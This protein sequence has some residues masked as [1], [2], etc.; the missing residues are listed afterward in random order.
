MIESVQ[1]MIL[2][3][4]HLPDLINAEHEMIRVHTYGERLEGVLA[5]KTEIGA[6]ITSCFEDLQQLAQQ[7]FGIWGEADCEGQAA[8]P[9]DLSNC[10]AMLEGITKALATRESGLALNVLTLQAERL[11]E[12]V[13]DFKSSMEKIRPLIELNRTAISQVAENYQTSTRILYEMY[14]Q[15]QATYTSQGQ[16]AKPTTTQS[17]I[18]VKA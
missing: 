15:S 2:L 3:Y 10:V 16:Q 17:T 12:K 14:E 8:Y 4:G 7:L 9:G 18:F 13:S 1:T 5:K 6:S 11:K